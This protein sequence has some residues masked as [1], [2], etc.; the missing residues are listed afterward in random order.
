MIFPQDPSNPIECFRYPNLHIVDN[1]G[2]LKGG[3]LAHPID[4]TEYSVAGIKI[5][6]LLYTSNGISTNWRNIN[7]TTNH[8]AVFVFRNVDKLEF[9]IKIVDHLIKF[10][11]F[12]SKEEMFNTTAISNVD[13]F[14]KKTLSISYLI[15]FFDSISI[16]LFPVY[17]K[18]D[19]IKNIQRK[20]IRI[21]W[22]SNPEEY[23]K[24]LEVSKSHI[25]EGKLHIIIGLFF[26]GTNNS[27]YNTDYGYKEIEKEVK[28]LET[29]N[30]LSGE[31]LFSIAL[32]Q[33]RE[34]NPK[35]TKFLNEGSSYLNDYTNIVNLY[36][37]YS[38][39]GESDDTLILKHY[40]QGLGPETKVDDNIADYHYS[41]K[42][43][44]IIGYEEDKWDELA[45][46]ASPRGRSSV[47]D[48]MNLSME[49]SVRKIKKILLETK[50]EIDSI[51]FD[52]FGFSRGA[53]VVRKCQNDI[54]SEIKFLLNYDLDGFA[55]YY[56]CKGGYFAKNFFETIC[57]KDVSKFKLS[58]PTIKTRFLGLFD[59]VD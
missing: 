15:S 6:L 28:K 22:K 24:Q 36:K 19:D 25:K 10:S 34:S 11:R 32:K 42:I 53:T 50:K 29:N 52:L 26:D 56:K 9:R 54:E 3:L 8:V 4:A 5:K 46:A 47:T 38:T 21:L 17:Y 23:K 49:I 14:N 13:Q 37:L 48:R 30:A 1:G 20:D 44:A 45:F 59:T 18:N 12:T 33:F 7:L 16:P 39:Q 35:K 55:N 57:G 58:F 43:S 41:D 40:I 51:T 27:R 31:D 2:V